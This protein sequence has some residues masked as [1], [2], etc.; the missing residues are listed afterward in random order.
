[1]EGALVSVAAGALKPVLGKL[2]TLLGDEYKRLRRLRK[3]I[4]FLTHEL[5]AMEAFF[6]KM[7]TQEDPDVQVKL[8]MTEVRELSYDIED[9][10][11]DFIE[12]AHDKSSKPG[13]MKKIKNLLDRT[14]APHKIAKAIEDLKKQV[15]EASERHKRY[16]IAVQS[17]D[18]M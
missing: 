3:G 2:A 13:F 12:Q 9:S 7:S 11:D 18:Q 14:K 4:D 15:T 6:V 1:M 17:R 8:W 10:L 16:A 5:S